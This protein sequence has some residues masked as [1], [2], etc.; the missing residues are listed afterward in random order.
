MGC[1]S[2][3]YLDELKEEMPEVDGWYGKFDWHNL[4]QSLSSR[5]PGTVKYERRITTPRHHAYIKIAEGCNRFC[6]FCAIPLITGRFH[7]RQIEEILDEVRST[8]V[9][10]HQRIQH[11]SP[12]FV[13]LRT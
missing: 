9:K 2:Q 10:W 4:V 1:L 11:N 7:S 6:S 3:R 5:N 12:G 8:C 13:K